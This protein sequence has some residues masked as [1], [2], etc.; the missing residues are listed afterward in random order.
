[1]QVDGTTGVGEGREDTNQIERAHLQNAQDHRRYDRLLGGKRRTEAFG[2]IGDVLEREAT[3]VEEHGPGCVRRQRQC[4]SE[5]ER[6]Q[7]LAPEVH[8]G[9]WLRPTG[10]ELL[11]CKDLFVAAHSGGERGRH[12]DRGVGTSHG[13]AHDGGRSTQGD[14]LP[15]DRVNGHQG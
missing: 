2:G 1:V 7:A 13:S 4:L 15:G 8:D 6:A 14:D 11:R 10:G 3:F 12:D 9:P 5:G